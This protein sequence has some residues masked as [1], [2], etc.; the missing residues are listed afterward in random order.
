MV[1]PA[2]FFGRGAWGLRSWTHDMR[3]NRQMLLSKI[4]WDRYGRSVELGNERKRWILAWCR[5]TI[6]DELF[7]FGNSV[8]DHGHGL[9]HFGLASLSADPRVR[10]RPPRCVIAERRARTIRGN[11]SMTRDDAHKPEA[12]VTVANAVVG[13]N[14][15]E[16]RLPADLESA[17]SPKLLVAFVVTVICIAVAI[18]TGGMYREYHWIRDRDQF[19]MK[20]YVSFSQNWSAPWSLRPFGCVPAEDVI[21]LIGAPPS[22]IETAKTLFPEAKSIGRFTSRRDSAAAKN[23]MTFDPKAVQWFGAAPEWSTKP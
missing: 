18:A 23:A 17:R 6:S 7:R 4:L 1:I 9:L 14:R 12:D 21:L 16:S 13:S 5:T 11:G 3:G 8:L 10:F 19:A 15:S 20:H 22:E 2:R